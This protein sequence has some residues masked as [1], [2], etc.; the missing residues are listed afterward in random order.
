MNELL[1][2]YGT[3]ERRFIALHNNC[4]NTAVRGTMGVRD[5]RTLVTGA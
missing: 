5:G 4:S 2:R 3:L 1:Q